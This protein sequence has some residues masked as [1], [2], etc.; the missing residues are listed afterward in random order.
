MIIITKGLGLWGS[1]SIPQVDKI[2]DF[3]K[4][5]E[6]LAT[7]CDTVSQETQAENSY[8]RTIIQNIPQNLP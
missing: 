5:Q 8:N 7:K 2:K 6:I 3:S 4:H 1:K